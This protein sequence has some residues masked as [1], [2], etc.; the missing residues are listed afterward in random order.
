M[1]D[2][3]LDSSAV[4]KNYLNEPGT[5][6][7]RNLTNPAAGHALYTTLLTGPEVVS[8]IFRKVRTGL[9]TIPAARRMAN[10]FRANWTQQYAIVATDL[11]LIIQAMDLAERYSLRGYDSV[12]LAVALDLQADRQARQL[13]PLTFVSADIEQLRVAAA[14]GLPTENPDQ[15]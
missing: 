7:I 8:A 9:L 12:H 11:T 1:A 15:H 3:Y 6:W 2:Y 14:L 5:I 13:P 10:N 4:A